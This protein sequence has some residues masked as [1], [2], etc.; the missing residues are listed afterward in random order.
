MDEIQLVSALCNAATFDV[1]TMN[2]PLAERNIKGDATDVAMLRLAEEISATQPLLDKYEKI[3]EIGFNSKN[4]WM[5]T[6]VKEKKQGTTI[7]L[8]IKGMF[9]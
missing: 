4:K 8:L 5:V 7:V 3:F 6:I 1:T 9:H 2:R